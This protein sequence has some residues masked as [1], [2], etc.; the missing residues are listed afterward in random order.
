MSDHPHVDPGDG[1]TECQK[2]GKWVFECIHSCKGVPVTVAAW[3]R[4][5]D[6]FIEEWHTAPNDDGTPLHHYLGMTWDEYGAW[7]KDP[8]AIPARW[9]S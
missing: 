4:Q 5:L 9:L 7:V 6:V 2:C 3:N 1:R 8:T